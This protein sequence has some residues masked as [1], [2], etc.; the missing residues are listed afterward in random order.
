M[1][2]NFSPIYGESPTSTRLPVN[3]DANGNIITAPLSSGTQAVNLTQ[4]KGTAIS[5]TNP[6]NVAPNSILASTATL[7]NVNGTVSSTT[8]LAANTARLGALIYNDSTAI[9]YLAYAS[10]AT[11][12][13][14][15][16]QVP[17][18][19][20]F[21]LPVAPVYDGIITA[22]WASANGAARVTEL[23]A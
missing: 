11:T 22:V 15:T 16:T 20:L 9:M 13:A 4:V 14:Y 5:A 3:V 10:T 8:L 6:V 19:A 12:T 21:E 7:T 17:S 18:Q 23:T 1:S 2:N